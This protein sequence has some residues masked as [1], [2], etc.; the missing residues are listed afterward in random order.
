VRDLPVA[1]LPDVRVSQVPQ[2]K[3]L[4]V[5]GKTYL[6]VAEIARARQQGPQSQ[7]SRFLLPAE[8]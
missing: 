1:K 4:G 3:E 8:I 5:A 2:Q 7:L 6:P